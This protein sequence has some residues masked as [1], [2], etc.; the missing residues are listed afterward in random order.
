M[1][2]VEPQGREREHSLVVSAVLGCDDGNRRSTTMKDTHAT[3]ILPQG[4]YHFPRL[5]GPGTSLSRP[6]VIRKNIGVAYDV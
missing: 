5:N 2:L 1:S 3:A 4:M 6:E